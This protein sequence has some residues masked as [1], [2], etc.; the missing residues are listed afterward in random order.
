MR[1]NRYRSAD[2]ITRR[3]T[4]SRRSQVLKPTT[5]VEFAVDS[6]DQKRVETFSRSLDCLHYDQSDD[7]LDIVPRSAVG[8][9]PSYCDGIA[10][11]PKIEDLEVDEWLLALTSLERFSASEC[12]IQEWESLCGFALLLCLLA[13]MSMYERKV[14]TYRTC[15]D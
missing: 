5:R 6:I 14:R 4:D 13:R 11:V 8:G 3:P 2:D 10:V 7:G 9:F 12:R 15:I 1:R